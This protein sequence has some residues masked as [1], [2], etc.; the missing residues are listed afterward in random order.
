MQKG[1]LNKVNSAVWTKRQKSPPDQ[2]SQDGTWSVKRRAMSRNFKRSP[3]FENLFTKLLPYVW[4]PIFNLVN[5]MDLWYSFNP[6]QKISSHIPLMLK[7]SKIT[8]KEL[9]NTVSTAAHVICE[10]S[11]CQCWN[12]HV[13]PYDFNLIEPVLFNRWKDPPNF[14]YQES[15]Q[16]KS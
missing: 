5:R 9:N 16:L 1:I 12:I 15:T 14:F 2:S 6:K 13:F 4:H 3:N 10:T 11:I 7:N 8:K